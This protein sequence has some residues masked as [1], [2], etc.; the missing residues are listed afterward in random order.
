MPSENATV[1]LEI[2]S[3]S[4]GGD[5]VAHHQGQ[6]VFVARAA[7]GD[8]VRV[9][10][11][12]SDA[13]S[14]RGHVLE[15]LQAG[16]HRVTPV[17]PLAERCG[18]CRWM[19]VAADAQANAKEQL[20]YDAL[21]R[22]G[23]VPR[24]ALSA[25]PLVRAP[26]SLAYR[27]RARLHVRRGEVGYLREGTHEL[28]AVD[29]CPVLEPTLDKALRSLPQALRDAGLLGRTSEIDLVCE[30]AAWS[31]AL[32]VDKLS[33]AMR[34]KAEV[35]VRQVGARGAVLLAPN[36]SPA[37]VREPELGTLRPDT[38]A[39][40]SAGSNSTLVEAAVEQLS[41]REGQQVLEL[42][43]GSG[44]FTLPMASRGAQVWAIEQAGP[45]L[46]LLRAAAD[47]RGLGARVRILEGDS[48]TLAKSLSSEGRRFDALVL[49]PPR[50]GCS[51]LGP[52]ARLLGVRRIV[53]VSCDPATLS[54]D[55]DELHRAGFAPKWAQPF[56][57]FPQTPHVEGIV[58]LEA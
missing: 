49:D 23:H 48:L 27:R 51:G 28:V 12:A 6:V 56:D 31:F 38:F 35:V 26:Q 44:N 20:F 36:E 54:R 25:Q 37:R 2:E 50:S 18:G 52:F 47:R 14:L 13:R 11:V 17:C 21:E 24:S 40:V 3:L 8:R 45:A 5:A 22:I 57:L 43:A 30:G 39:Q 16:P 15:V 42:F 46:R 33:G 10:L 32:H 1:E 4:K 55:V 7:P 34:S 29:A 58:R 19:H 9:E 41:V 53:Y